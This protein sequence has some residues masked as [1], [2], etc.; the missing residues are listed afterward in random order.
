MKMETIRI[1]L[2]QLKTQEEVLDA[3]RMLS[4][5]SDKYEGDMESLREI[6]SQW[7][8]PLKVEVILGGDITPFASIMEI[9]EEARVANDKLLF[10]VI[11]EIG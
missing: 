5:M 10:V 4:G 8:T 2:T 11:M 3:F 1:D 6:L 9:L 7:S